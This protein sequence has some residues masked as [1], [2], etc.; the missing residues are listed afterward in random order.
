MLGFTLR[1]LAVSVPVVLLSTVVVFV[2]VSLSGDPLDKLR[3][4]TPPPPPQV[5]A[6]E[7]H[8]LHLDQSMPHRYWTWLTG[9]LHGDLGPSVRANLH[10]G[11]EIVTRV[12]VTMR[13]VAAAFVLALVIA[14]VVGV[15]SAVKQYTGIDHFF[16]FSAFLFLSMPSFWFAI[17]LKQAGVSLNAHLNRQVVYTIGEKSVIAP[18]GAWARLNDLAGHLILPTISLALV[19]FGAWSR[20]QRA[21]MLE[22]LNSDYVRLARAKGLRP[23]RI[24]VRHAL[25]NALT[26]L[27]TVTALDLAALVSG[28]VLTETVF[29][30]HGMGDLLTSSIAQRDVYAVLAWLLV[31]AVA[32]VVLNLIADL[33]YML[34]DPRVRHA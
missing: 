23:R 17:L 2:M 9:L 15:V 32:I 28:A 30:W 11:H 26:P 19:S 20:F 25:R 4:R 5:V 8:R 14:I 16:S 31:A 29:Q 22:V 10:I 33:L 1:R 21:S 6:I 18:P 34:L 27:V 24:L 3:S 7:R 13:L 12:G